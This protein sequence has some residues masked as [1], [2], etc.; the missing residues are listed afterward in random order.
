[1]VSGTGSDLDVAHQIVKDW[2]FMS[3][4]TGLLKTQFWLQKFLPSIL[5]E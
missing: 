4:R 3:V 2:A 1:M 5:P